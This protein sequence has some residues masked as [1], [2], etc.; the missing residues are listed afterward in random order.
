MKNALNDKLGQRIKTVRIAKGMNISELCKRASISRSYYYDVEKGVSVPSSQLL[1][2]I[3]AA[4][5]VSSDFLLDLDAPVKVKPEINLR[6]KRLIKSVDIIRIPILGEVRGG[7]AMF[8]AGNIEGYTSHD[9]RSLNSD[10]TYFAL[11]VTGDSMNKLIRAGDLVIVEQT[12][13]VENGDI[14]IVLINGD[15]ATIKRVRYNGDKV[16][17]IPESDNSTHEPKQFPSDAVQIIGK[18]IKS[19]RSFN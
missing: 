14:A 8:A 5:N 1:N 3:A 2:R 6:E 12:S 9:M 16:V 7:L 13:M 15:E 10:K 18:V 4:L 19:E 17:L 11:K